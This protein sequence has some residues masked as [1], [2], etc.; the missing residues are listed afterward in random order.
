MQQENWCNERLKRNGFLTLNEVYECL[1]LPKTTAGMVAGWI[2]DEDHPV[3]DNKV[4]F[5]LDDGTS[6]ATRRFMNGLEPIV[7]L[8]FNI[9]GDIYKLMD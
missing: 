5:N 3:G 6:E 4:L 1:D 8:D 9:D 7:L 2:Y